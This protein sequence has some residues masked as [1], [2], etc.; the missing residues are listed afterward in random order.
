M[1]NCRKGTWRSALMLNSV[2]TKQE[3]ASHGIDMDD[4]MWYTFKTGKKDCMVINA[5]NKEAGRHTITGYGVLCQCFFIIQVLQTG[6]FHIP[7][8]LSVYTSPYILVLLCI[9]HTL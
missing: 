8:L 5:D 6:L 4:R 7:A 9:L 2:L 3:I 1:A